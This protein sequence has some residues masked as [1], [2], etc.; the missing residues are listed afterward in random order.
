MLSSLLQQPNIASFV[1]FVLHVL[2]GLLGFS[3]LFEKLPLYLEWIL[4]VFSPF[5]FTAGISQVCQL[6][7][8]LI[9]SVYIINFNLWKI[10]PAVGCVWWVPT[11][12]RTMRSWSAALAK[13]MCITLL[14]QQLWIELTEALL[15]LVVMRK[16]CPAWKQHYDYEWTWLS[17]DNGHD[18]TAVYYSTTQHVVFLAKGSV[19]SD[20]CYFVFP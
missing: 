16:C 4:N 17:G 2:F 9:S 3:T 20:S 6:Y 15:I 14:V 10:I 19:A 18:D 8:E 5:A 1:G 11:S 13:I 7:P 12:A